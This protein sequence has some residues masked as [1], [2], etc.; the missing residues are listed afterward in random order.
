MSV[1]T[2]NL[3]DFIHQATKKRYILFYHFPFGSRDLH[4]VCSHQP[5]TRHLNGPMGV[6]QEQRVISQYLPESEI[7]YYYVHKTQPIM[8]CHDQEPLNFDLLPG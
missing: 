6:P 1:P 4:D 7:D 2:H 5:D 8:F 3:Y